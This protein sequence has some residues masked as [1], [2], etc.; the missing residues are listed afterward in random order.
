MR[1]LV[2]VLRDDHVEFGKSFTDGNLALAC[3]NDWLTR[4]DINSI[5]IDDDIT[6]VDRTGGLTARNNEGT[7]KVTIM[8]EDVYSGISWVG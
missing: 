1:Y 7:M 3:A 8:N 4:A 5:F 6:L 2:I